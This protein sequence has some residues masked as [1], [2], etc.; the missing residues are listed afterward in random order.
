MKDIREWF[1]VYMMPARIALDEMYSARPKNPKKEMRMRISTT[2][3]MSVG[4][5]RVKST[6]D[7]SVETYL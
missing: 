3:E 2:A 1:A 6:W 5:G 7:S 4:A